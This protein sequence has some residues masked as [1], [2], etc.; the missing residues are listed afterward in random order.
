MTGYDFFFL[1]FAVIS[2]YF[3]FEKIIERVTR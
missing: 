2:A 1:L 3:L